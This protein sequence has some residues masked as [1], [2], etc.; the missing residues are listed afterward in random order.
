MVLEKDGKVSFIE[1]CRRGEPLIWANAAAVSISVIAVIGLLL[2]LAV[3]G[4]SH[5][6]PADIMQAQYTPPN[7]PARRIEV[8]GEIAE[9]Q[10]VGIDQLQAA[11]IKDI[12]TIG[13]AYAP[14]A[15]VH[16]VASGHRYARELDAND[17]TVR[18][19]PGDGAYVR[20]GH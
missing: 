11:G 6:W 14:G 10:L 4:F 7:D 2:L 19:E 12:R 20:G 18:V 17:L 13:D 5:F 3:R 9:E 8:I 1:W 15:I 16:A